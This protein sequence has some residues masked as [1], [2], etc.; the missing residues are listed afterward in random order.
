MQIALEKEFLYPVIEG[1]NISRFGLK[2]KEDMYYAPF[3][4]YSDDLKKPIAEDILEQRAPQLYSFYLNYKGLFKKTKYNERVQGKKGAFYSMTRVGKYSFAKY[5]VIFR[6]NSKWVASVI[7]EYSSPLLGKKMYLLL[8]HACSISEDSD[9]NFITLDE[10]HYICSILNSPIINSYIINSSDS[11]SFK[12]DIPIKIR[13]Y[14]NTLWLHRLLTE[15]SFRAHNSEIKERDIDLLL[16]YS[17]LRY[18]NECIGNKKRKKEDTIL[19]EKYE[20]IQASFFD[21]LSHL[22]TL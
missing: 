6:N 15:I 10:A 1:P 3:P 14:K 16:D 2:F 5:R 20:N 22:K 8:D 13:K 21:I 4:Y 11:R 19:E 7:E 18:I 12:T 17:M 9:G